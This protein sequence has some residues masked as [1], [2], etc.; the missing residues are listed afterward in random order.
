MLVCIYIVT[1]VSVG[2]LANTLFSAD[3]CKG[4]N[5]AGSSNPPAQAP[6]NIFTIVF[7]ENTTHEDDSAYHQPNRVT[8][9]TRSETEE[10]QEAYQGKVYIDERL[11]VTH[12]RKRF[13]SNS[14]I[15]SSV[16]SG[17]RQ[18][19]PLKLF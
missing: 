3:Q 16:S 6:V 9:S 12:H 14:V 8:F 5:G 10:R 1:V 7:H 2:L 18:G 13:V 19:S 17:F 11:K 15:S 4:L